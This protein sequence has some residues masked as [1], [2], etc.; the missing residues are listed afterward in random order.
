MSTVAA[1]QASQN[2]M[3]RLGPVLLLGLLV[4]GLA[5]LGLTVLLSIGQATAN[6]NALAFKQAIWIGLGL[7]VCLVA[8]CVDLEKLRPWAPVVGAAVVVMLVL[9]LIPEIGHKVNGARRWI[10]ISALGMSLQVSDFAKVGMVFV[11]AHYLA[12][13]HRHRQTFWRGFVLPLSFIGL[14]AGLILIEPDYGTALLVGS[15][16][17]LMLFLAGARMMFLVPT[18]L[19][20]GVGFALAIM[21]DPVRWRRILAFIDLE[22]NKSDAAYQLWQGILAFGVGGLRGVGLGNGRQQMD[23]LPEAQTDFILPIIG[24]ELGLLF[25]GGVTIAFLLI[26][27][28][29]FL[30]LRRAPNPFQFLIAAGALLFITLQALINIC[31][32]TGLVP[33]KGMS[34]PFVS[35]GGSNLVAM[36]MLVGLVL[37]GFWRWRPVA[38]LR[39]LEL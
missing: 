34:L 33:T 13:D 36:F 15:V 32:V 8:A 35:Y 19:V 23:F 14:V 28:F 29:G 5:L 26:F 2:P 3:R 7:M 16:G 10:R 24:E 18:A 17:G 9:V 21:Q 39:P 31:V 12:L 20:G 37:N 38:P 25:T 11:L 22:G 6:A 4:L 27:I 1:Q 30:N